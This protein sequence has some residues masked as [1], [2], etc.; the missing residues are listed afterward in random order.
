MHITV[1]LTVGLDSS[2]LKAQSSICESEGYIVTSTGSVKE[3]I[4]RFR[5]GDFDIVLLGHSIPIEDRERLAFQIRASGS[6]TPVISMA[7]STG[8]SDWFRDATL[9][10]DS[11]AL[12]SGA[13][14]VATP[15]RKRTAQII[16]H[17][18]ANPEP[19]QTGALARPADC[20]CGESTTGGSTDRDWKKV[21]PVVEHLD[22]QTDNEPQASRSGHFCKCLSPEAM[23]EF[24]SLATQFPCEGNAI[25]FAEE[26]QPGKVLILLKGRVRLSMNSSEGR[27]LTLGI[28]EPGDVLGLAA[29]ISGCPYETT[30]E[31]RFPCQIAS[32]PR[33][34]FLDFLLRYPVAGQN[35]SRQLSLDYRRACGHL[36]ILGLKLTASE[37]L[38]RLLLEWCAEGERTERGARIQCALTHE[39]IGEYICVARE[40]VSRTLADLKNRELV[41]QRGSTLVISS[42]RALEVYAGQV[43]R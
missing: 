9:K 3:A 20:C 26:D 19:L 31:T 33:Q 4:E 24:E 14:E 8:G 7:K 43:D 22:K 15:A 23:N 35:V 13:E 11:S 10:S 21:T 25:L 1:V 18:N 38:A 37:K 36:R 6:R 17:R 32:L 39:E 29:A 12:L 42:L 16:P 41:E 40:T 34:A 28:A 27:R 30:A 5:T 2:L